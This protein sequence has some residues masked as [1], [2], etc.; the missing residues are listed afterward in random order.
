MT[1]LL[2]C[3]FAVLS[4]HQELSHGP[5]CNDSISQP[6]QHFQPKI[7]TLLSGEPPAH[8]SVP[9]NSSRFSELVQ[10]FNFIPKS[11]SF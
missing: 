11:L 9:L 10:E 4:H 3:S 1:V 5:F 8:I 7:E 6:Q 2:P